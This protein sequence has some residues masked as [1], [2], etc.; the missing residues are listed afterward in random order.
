MLAVD[1]RELMLSIFLTAQVR[2]L[3]SPCP[4]FSDSPHQQIGPESGLSSHH[5]HSLWSTFGHCGR[6]DAHLAVLLSLCSLSSNPGSAAGAMLSHLSHTGA[7]L[8]S[9]F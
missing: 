9:H 8:C 5:P 3:K 1:Q 2:S 4:L 6:G 7:L